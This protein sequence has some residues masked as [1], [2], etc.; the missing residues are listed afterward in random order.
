[1]KILFVRE[2][3]I[4]GA[5]SGPKVVAQKLLEHLSEKVE[6]ILFPRVMYI[7]K[8]SRFRDL[9]SKL[10]LSYKAVVTSDVDL[11]HFITIPAITDFA[12][13]SIILL[14]RLK[15]MPI[16]VNIHGIVY[17]KDF[18][19]PERN[20]L[21]DKLALV[22]HIRAQIASKVVVNSHYMKRLTSSYYKIPKNKITVIPNGVDTKGFTPSGDKINLD[23]DPAILYV[24]KISLE[25]GIDVLIKALRLL[26]DDLRKAKLHIVGSGSWMDRAILLAQKL[27]VHSYIRFH[28]KVP[29]SYLPYVFRGADI[30][31]LPSRVEA[32]GIVLLEAMA[33][34]LPVVASSVGGIP[35]IVENSENGILVP[36]NDPVKL[37][38]AIVEIHSD[39]D[40]RRK[41]S[42]N[43]LQTAL[44]YSWENVADIYLKLYQ[45]LTVG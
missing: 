24:G 28:G 12:A 45:Q 35:E 16:I 44:K 10:S 1:M 8:I 22:S 17:K 31:V 29:H 42:A 18:H 20:I 30:F 37:S 32:F 38:Q 3:L 40:L 39:S 23:G 7:N 41:L 26:K 4:D 33:C 36:P 5:P 34:G 2:P 6:V 19:D 21:R 14:G 25:K 27:D 15:K 11:I 9:I 13:E 43:A